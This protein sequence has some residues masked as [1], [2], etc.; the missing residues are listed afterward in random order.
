MGAVQWA[1]DAREDLR[2]IPDTFVC[3]EILDLA[4]RELRTPD[5]SQP[6]FEGRAADNPQIF[7]RRAMPLADLEAFLSW[8]LDDKDEYGNQACDYVLVYRH[9]TL[10]EAIKFKLHVRKGEN[11]PFVVLRV[12]HNR[13]F[14]RRFQ[15][16]SPPRQSLPGQVLHPKIRR[17]WPF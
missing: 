5:S 15:A 16:A 6:G 13:E 1:R 8:D 14:A 12:L 9:L 17:R 3:A 2:Q 11:P 7:Y 10:N 4:D